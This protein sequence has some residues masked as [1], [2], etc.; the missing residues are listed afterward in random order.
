VIKVCNWPICQEIF[1]RYSRR[2]GGE[3]GESPR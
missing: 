3:S 2:I 1:H